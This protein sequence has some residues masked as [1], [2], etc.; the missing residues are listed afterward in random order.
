MWEPEVR[1]PCLVVRSPEAQDRGA[2]LEQPLL[3]LELEGEM[4]E[5]V[6]L[7]QREVIL[8]SQ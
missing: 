4:E 2:E 1:G 7:E 5:E 6:V 8:T 3:E